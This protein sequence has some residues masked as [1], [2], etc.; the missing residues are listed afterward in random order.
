MTI[1]NTGRTSTWK[2]MLS[3]LPALTI[4][5]ALMSRAKTEWSPNANQQSSQKNQETMKAMKGVVRFEEIPVDEA[6]E[7]M[8]LRYT[9]VSVDTEKELSMEEWIRIISNPGSSDLAQKLT[10]LLKVRS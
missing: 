6:Y 4:I 2:W 1:N 9:A 7:K 10:E 5:F 3:L 8:A